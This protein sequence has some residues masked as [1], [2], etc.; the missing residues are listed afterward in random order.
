MLKKFITK[1]ID[2]DGTQLNSHFALLNTGIK[3]DS[4]VSFTGSCSV[5]N[6][7]LV[8]LEDKVQGC[9]IVSRL[10]LHFIVEH[11]DS[12]LEKAILRQ[13]LLSAIASEEINRLS[14]IGP[15]VRKGDDLYWRGRKL[16]VSIASLSPV[17][18][19]IHMGMNIVSR[20]TPV[21]AAGLEDL[22]INPR[23]LSNSIMLRYV[24]EIKSV[25]EARCKVRPV[26]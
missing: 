16:S 10:M 21:R 9:K 6:D 18:S 8:D 25:S 19:V 13:R 2:Y 5:A 1:R 4:I 23:K 15:T 12:D 7:N 3:G 20:G 17:S 26:G 14:K 11:F 24:K 22:G